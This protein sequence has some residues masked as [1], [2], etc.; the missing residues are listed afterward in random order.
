MADL[1]RLERL[2][3]GPALAGLRAR[4]R[5]RYAQGRDGG[6]VTLGQL[7]DVERAA[8][9]GMLGRPTASGAS[10]R[11]E[12]ADLDDVLLHSGAAASLREALELLD[13]PIHDLKAQRTT[14][15]LAWSDFHTS[16]A[17][18]RL[19]ALLAQPRA[20]G[21]LKRACGGEPATAAALC[22]DAAKVLAAL[23]RQG[24]TRSQL[25]AQVL[26]DAHALDNGR[27][28]AS[29]VL[30]A[31]RHALADELEEGEQEESARTQWA[32][33][34]ILVNELARPALALNLPGSEERRGEPDYLSL[35]A[36]VRT[37]RNWEVA[38]RD[39]F[40]C[41]N[42]NV[43]AIAA[44]VLGARCAPLVCTDG[45]PAAAQ[46]ALLSQLAAAGARLHYH[47]DFDWPGIAIANVVM[48][49]FGAR[50][51]RFGEQDYRAAAGAVA[52]SSR[53][54][55]PRGRDACWDIGLKDAMLRLTTPVDEEAVVDVLLADL[56]RGS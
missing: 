36:L 12:V 15:A 41:E 53:R 40:V 4:L 5:K 51:W 44:D 23:P 31:L 27:P 3:G 42:P 7:D 22:G 19:A 13:G 52:M 38:Q 6:T 11:F 37:S 1:A 25:A 34:G 55:E 8:L 29:L 46:R 26:G 20:L 18:P 17:E 50:P 45:M 39:V 33:V 49:D 28:V 32:A 10:L 56:L 47:G 48:Q 16:L 21:A 30:A 54:L 2:L 43:V 14:A 35:R 9:C 24:S